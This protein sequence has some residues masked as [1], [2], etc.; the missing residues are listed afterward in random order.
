MNYRLA[1][2]LLL[3]VISAAATA[4][5]PPKPPRL[6]RALQSVLDLPVEP[7]PDSSQ[8]EDLFP[9]CKTDRCRIEQSAFAIRQLYVLFVQLEKLVTH[10]SLQRAHMF[11]SLREDMSGP[12]FTLF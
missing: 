8:L 11:Q 3:L 4:T 7:K 12:R 10:E 5:E 9:W 1:S 6:P 2:L